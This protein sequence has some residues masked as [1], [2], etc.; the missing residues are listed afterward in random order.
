LAAALVYALGV[1]AD[2]GDPLQELEFTTGNSE[3][4]A[5]QALPAFA[6]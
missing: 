1:G 4:V 2:L 3:G 5:Q 6:V